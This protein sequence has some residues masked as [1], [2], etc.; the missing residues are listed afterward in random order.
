MSFSTALLIGVVLGE[1]E[2]ELGEVEGSEADAA[3]SAGFAL[4]LGSSESH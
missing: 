4:R 1:V 3:T 2:S